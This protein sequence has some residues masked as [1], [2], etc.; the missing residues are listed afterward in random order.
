ML[1]QSV[2]NQSF[3][4]RLRAQTAASHLKLEG[5]PVSKAIISADLNKAGY[6]LYLN[7]MADVINDTETHIFQMLQDIILDLDQRKKNALILEDLRTIGT[8]KDTFLPVF[9]AE[10]KTAAFALGIFYVVEGSALGGRYILKN[11]TATLGFDETNGA[12]YFAGYGNH[13]GSFWKNFLAA[14]TAYEIESG[15]GADIIAGAGYAFT[16]I[17]EH[18][19]QKE[20]AWI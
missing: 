12:S 20:I 7:L 10:N 6:A 3:L 1:D 19:S 2:T 8:A 5:L 17:Y 14:M 11:V 18:L 16:A 9:E 13:T 4:D 15:E